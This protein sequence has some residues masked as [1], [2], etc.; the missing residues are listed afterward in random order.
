M[1]VAEGRQPPERSNHL[2]L[3]GRWRR[4]EEEGSVFAH[5]EVIW[6]QAGKCGRVWPIWPGC[7]S[8]L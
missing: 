4:L 7:C 3:V 6:M 5:R 1:G 8:L 2:P